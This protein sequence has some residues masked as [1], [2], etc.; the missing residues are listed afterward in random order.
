MTSY[1]CVLFV[2]GCV[3]V[4]PYLYALLKYSDAAR[5]WVAANDLSLFTIALIAIGTGCAIES[6]RCLSR[7]ALRA[8]WRP[9]K[10]SKVHTQSD[11]FLAV[12]CQNVA[13]AIVIATGGVYWRYADAPILLLGALVLVV[14]SF[15]GAVAL[16]RLLGCPVPAAPCQRSEPSGTSCR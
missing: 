13:I 3:A 11:S 10:A 9:V 12:A 4:A 1:V 7:L 5:R 6:I 8:V 2:P 15:L 14:P 16:A